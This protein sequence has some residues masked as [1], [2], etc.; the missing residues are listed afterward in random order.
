MSLRQFLLKTLSK[1]DLTKPLTDHIAGKNHTKTHRRCVGGVILIIGVLIS[2]LG[3]DIVVLHVVFDAF[4]YALHGVG[5]IPF[6]ADIEK[7]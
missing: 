7:E 5:L 1:C 6:I 3:G 2:K 4:G